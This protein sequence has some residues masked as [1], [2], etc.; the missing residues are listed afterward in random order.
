MSQGGCEDEKR[1]QLVYLNA[2]RG[3]K[4]SWHF[5]PFAILAQSMSLRETTGGV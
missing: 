3:E 2:E 1:G 4:A 5:I